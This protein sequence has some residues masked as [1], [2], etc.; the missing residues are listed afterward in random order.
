MQSVKSEKKYCKTWCYVT[1]KC[2]LSV[3]ISGE[4][5][6]AYIAF[7]SWK[8]HIEM[9][10]TFIFFFCS[11]CL[12]VFLSL[13]SHLLFV[14]LLNTLTTH[15]HAHAHTF[16]YAATKGARVAKGNIQADA[17]IIQTVSGIGAVLHQCLCMMRG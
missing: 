8:I 16:T 10:S 7:C 6:E 17:A 11:L 4:W 9:C 1:K 13:S 2:A 12:C 3:L 14:C 15:T 5:E